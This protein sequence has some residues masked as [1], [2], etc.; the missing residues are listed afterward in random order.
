MSLVMSTASP[1]PVS[2]ESPAVDEDARSA[3]RGE[4]PPA[5]E[6]V[7]GTEKLKANASRRSL[8]P[9]RFRV[10]DP[11]GRPGPRR[12]RRL[13]PFLAFFFAPPTAPSSPWTASCTCSRTMSRITVTRLFRRGIVVLPG[14]PSRLFR[15]PCPPSRK[16]VVRHRYK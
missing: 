7:A 4:A 3:P 11:G 1:R 10:F 14:A 13:R 5:A 9:R 12:L 2:D 8:Y 15:E 16:L 6:G